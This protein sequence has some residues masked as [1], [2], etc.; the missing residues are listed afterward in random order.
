MEIWPNSKY[1]SY[2]LSIR[3]QKIKNN[4]HELY[5]VRIVKLTNLNNRSLE[6]SGWTANQ[7]TNSSRHTLEIFPGF[8]N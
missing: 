2:S 5:Y 1:R 3:L 7:P 4:P 8:N 6:F